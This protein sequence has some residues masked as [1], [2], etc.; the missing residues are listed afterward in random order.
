[1]IKKNF[2]NRLLI[3]DEYHNLRDDDSSGEDDKDEQK[4]ALKNLLKIV[5]NADNLRLVLLTAT[6]MFNLSEEIFNLLNILL[7]NDKRPIIDYKQ[8]IKDNIINDEGMDVL[9]KNLKDM[10]FT[11]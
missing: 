7:L 2:S 1:M 10:L 8:Y 3:V 5:E 6:P 9:K 4:K 11:W